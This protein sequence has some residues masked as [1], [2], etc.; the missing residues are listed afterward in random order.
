MTQS[1]HLYREIQRMVEQ[2][3]IE[4]S[5]AVRLLL[6]SHAQ[7]LAEMGALKK[8]LSEAQRYPSLTWLWAHRRK[9]VVAMLVVVFV[10]YTFLFS[11]W[12]ISDIRHALLQ[13]TGLPTDLGI[14]VTPT[15]LP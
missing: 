7:L 5:E 13:L 10:V 3:D 2:G 14:G 15:P 9:D 4:T 1:E 8:E 11:P 6:L 12:H